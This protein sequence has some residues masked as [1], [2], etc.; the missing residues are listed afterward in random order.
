MKKFYFVFLIIFSI[1]ANGQNFSVD[2]Y[3]QFRDGVKGISDSEL[4]QMYSRPSEYYL[5]GF[6]DL[7]GLKNASYL[8]SMIIK[9]GITEDELA[10]LN[11]NLFFVTE[12]LSYNH[13]GNAFNVVY[14][15]DLPAFIST[16]AVLH[17]L[18]MSY[19][20]ILETLERELMSVYLEDFLQSLYV[21][22]N[23]LTEKYGDDERLSDGLKDA[24]LFITI[25]YSLIT[26]QLQSPHIADTEKLNEVWDAIN[27]E[28][29]A[30]MP[31]FTFP[32]RSRHLDFSQFTVRGHYVYTEEQMWMG[33]KSLEPYF[34]TMMWLGRTDFLLTPPADNPWEAPWGE[35]EILRMNIGAF[36]VNELMQNSDK[37]NLL[38]FNEQVINYLVGESD[39]IK[40]SEYQTVL[41]QIGISSAE[42]LIDTTTF[43]L[44]LDK[45]NQ[46][47]EFGQKIL[48]D[49]FFMDPYSEKPGVL[50][51]SY[52]VSGQ[53]FI[54][55]SYI[56]GSLVFD[57]LVSNGVKIPRMMP[58]PMDILFPLGNN[59]VLPL[60]KDEFEKYPYEEQLANLRYLV[61]NKPEDFWTESL[62]NVW[63]NS[64]RE[65]NPVDNQNQ[66]LFM[67]TAAWH[68]EKINTQLASW[69]QLR[70]DNLLYAKQSYTGMWG[71]SFPYSYIE[72]YPEF[73]ANLKLFAENA[74][75]FFNQLP[76]DN[77]EFIKITS[78]FNNF[79]EI[80][81][82]LSVLAQKELVGVSFSTEE[83]EW[84]KSMLSENQGECGA[85]PYSGWFTDLFFDDWDFTEND[86]TI[87]DIHT[88]PTDESGNLVGK[89]LHTGVGKVNLGVFIVNTPGS[90]G[91][92]MA[93]AGP[94]MSYYENTTVNFKRMTDQEWE[95]I[96]FDNKVPIRPEWTNI[97][98]ADGSGKM[99]EKSIELPSELY[100]GVVDIHKGKNMMT[101]YP[102]PVT[103][104]LTL[105]FPT[106]KRTEGII[107]IYNSNGIL[108]NKII[109]KVFEP[110]M[111]NESISFAGF[112]PGFYLVKFEDSY[113]NSSIIKVIKK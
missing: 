14:S 83:N 31:L 67:Q 99:K 89:I 53:R 111:N 107:S 25:A 40:P 48:S 101:A 56:L 45:L 11:D 73:Y 104:Q 12:R 78:F 113:H 66:P 43:H 32:Y 68:H 18:H 26:D 34:R 28:Q 29:A 10:L 80:N 61:D 88:Q 27:A 49:M 94:V 46:D 3:I 100:V 95:E 13:F 50:P 96:V 85:P 98:L 41:N 8:D 59:D 36:M 55:D 70:H 69:S 24:D 65:L 58:K 47:S 51:I 64:L 90:N 81:G 77:Y 91:E 74:G 44:L 37:L 1:V 63:M 109:N 21:N 79:A 72:P 71:C 84:L 22:F 42:Q 6:D 57:R 20:K 19:D 87:V 38:Q 76:T 82:K 23:S 7:N 4:Q 52:R 106:D 105:S 86:Y 35:E 17:A 93:F 75:N 39:N 15:N 60:L 54:L 97:Y 108:I 16:D 112:K 102:N 110:G 9:L 92:T 2:D 62:Y 30:D 5:K 103:D 33:I